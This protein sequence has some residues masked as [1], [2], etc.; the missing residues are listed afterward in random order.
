MSDN[1]LG[2]RS[3][4]SDGHFET[5]IS[6]GQA[7]LRRIME[8]DSRPDLSLTADGS[9]NGHG[10]KGSVSARNVSPV[11]NFRL[12]KS[13]VEVLGSRPISSDFGGG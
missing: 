3:G 6:R 9:G 8:R 4:N 13:T 7:A 11:Q 2:D 12:R 5:D 10:K 1:D